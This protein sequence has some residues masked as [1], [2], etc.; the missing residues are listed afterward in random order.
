MLDV[1]GTARVV[2]LSA[3][4]ALPTNAGQSRE[5]ERAPNTAATAAR[6][7]HSKTIMAAAGKW[8]PSQAETL[9]T[10]S[11]EDCRRHDDGL[12]PPTLTTTAAA[13]TCGARVNVA[14]FHSA[15]DLL[16]QQPCVCC[17]LEVGGII[18]HNLASA[19]KSSYP[20]GATPVVA[21]SEPDHPVGE[22]GGGGEELGVKREF[23]QGHLR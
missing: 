10:L 9:A 15:M 7:K 8:R 23:F 3:A 2:A 11:V 12:P 1:Q 20:L 16:G 5:A 22:D 4:A 17:G 14:V 18:K 19:A 13:A 21:T 6:N